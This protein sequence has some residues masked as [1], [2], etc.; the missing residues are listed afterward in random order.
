MNASCQKILN[1]LKDGPKT[2]G[3]LTGLYSARYGA[4]IK[5]LRDLGYQIKS[6]KLPGRTSQWRYT[7]TGWTEPVKAVAYPVSS[8]DAREYEDHQEPDWRSREFCAACLL[9]GEHD[10]PHIRAAFRIGPPPAQTLEQAA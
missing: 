9:Y 3:D 6:E 8:Q 5:D 1:A 10:G 4:R 2:S 7:L